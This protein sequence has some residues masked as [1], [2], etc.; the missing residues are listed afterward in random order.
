MT[1]SHKYSIDAHLSAGAGIL[2]VNIPKNTG[3]R[4]TTEPNVTLNGAKY[5]AA[6]LIEKDNGFQSKNYDVSPVK[7]KLAL[8][9]AVGGLNLNPIE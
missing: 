9:Q 1:L 6:G 8:G 5:A 2:N 4:I 3:L 7:I